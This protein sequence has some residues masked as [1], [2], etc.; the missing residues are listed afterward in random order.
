MAPLHVVSDFTSEG[1]PETGTAHCRSV[2]R[3]PARGTVG[4][5]KIQERSHGEAPARSRG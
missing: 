4:N 1:S 5:G 3:R 2:V